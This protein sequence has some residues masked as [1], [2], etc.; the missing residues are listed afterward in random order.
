MYRAYPLAWDYL[1]LFQTQCV[2][3]PSFGLNMCFLWHLATPTAMCVRPLRSGERVP[4]L[5]HKR[6]QLPYVCCW[7]APTGRWGLTPTIGAGLA[8]SS[9][10]E[11]KHCFN[12]CC[13]FLGN[14][15]TRT[16]L[17]EV[18]TTRSQ[19]SSPANRQQ[20]P[21]D[22]QCERLISPFTGNPPHHQHPASFMKPFLHSWGRYVT[23]EDCS[24]RETQVLVLAL[25]YL[26]ICLSFNPSEPQ[27]SLSRDRPPG[28]KLMQQIKR[29][30]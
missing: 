19:T 27:M 4:L 6:G 12:Q 2:L 23:M 21:C 14:S 24:N 13:A 11:Y 29:I 7:E 25:M 16:Q 17:A 5:Q 18:P 3:A 20:M 9:R 22:Q 10:C 28:F 30:K 15:Q 8:L 1:S 26:L